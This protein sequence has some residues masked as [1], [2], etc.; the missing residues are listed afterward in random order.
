MC[1]LTGASIRH[2]ES[3]NIIP[4][5]CKTSLRR[6]AFGL[7]E[8]ELVFALQDMDFKLSFAYLGVV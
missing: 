6:I 3:R 1:G 7:N 8:A 2:I 5:E 4:K